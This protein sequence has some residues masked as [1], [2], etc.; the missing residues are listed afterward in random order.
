MSQANLPNM[1]AGQLACF[2][3]ETITV[4]NSVKQLTADTFEDTDGFAKRVVITIQSAQ[5]RWRYDGTD[6]T[7][8]IGHISNPFD[9]IVLQTTNN[10]K[11][12]R[13]IRAGGTNAT[14][15]ISYEH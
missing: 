11:N 9:T 2:A 6:P 10:I 8:S 7:S 1:I 12:F 4:T 13:V 3:F 5:I 15:S 14:L